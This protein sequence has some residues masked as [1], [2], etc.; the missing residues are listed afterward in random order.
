MLSLG[1][2]SKENDRIQRLEE[3][4]RG[5][6]GE[7]VSERMSTQCH[8]VT[9]ISVF[10]AIFEVNEGLGE[11]QAMFALPGARSREML[12]ELGATKAE[13]LGYHEA[14]DELRLVTTASSKLKN[15]SQ[16]LV[17]LGNVDKLR[18]IMRNDSGH[19]LAQVEYADDLWK[20][21]GIMLQEQ[22]EAHVSLMVIFEEVKI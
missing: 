21:M 18:N 12:Y 10:G 2:K 17:Q 6:N 4:A 9:V 13:F 14:R 22:G 3:R 11:D 19:A 7:V 5:V 15:L 16:S 8:Q 20:S 1:V